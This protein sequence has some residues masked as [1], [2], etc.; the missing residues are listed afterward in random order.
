MIK[1][2]KNKI[3]K[4]DISKQINLTF[5]SSLSFA[6][7]IVEQTIKILINGLKEKKILRIKNFGVFKVLEKKQRTGINP[8]TK[9]K[10]TICERRVVTFKSSQNLKSKLIN[11]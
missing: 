4:K 3:I 2:K 6:N 5:G 9:E 7:D 1:N 10:H 11:R 8:K